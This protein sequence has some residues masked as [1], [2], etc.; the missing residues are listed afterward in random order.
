VNRVYAR[1]RNAGDI[2]ITDDIEVIFKIVV[3]QRAGQ[4]L[5]AGPEGSDLETEIGRASVLGGLGPR[6]TPTAE[7]VSE[8]VEWQPTASNESHVCIRAY[9][10]PVTGERN[11]TLNNSAQENITQWYSPAAS[12]FEPVSFEI[13]TESPWSNRTGQVLMVVPDV[14]KGWTVELEDTDFVLAPGD[15]FRQKVTITP[16]LAAFHGEI[17][18]RGFFSSYAANIE[19][20]TLVGDRFVPFGGTT[21]VV[22]PVNKDSKLV[23]TGVH[24]E[25]QFGRPNA[26]RGGITSTGP[27][28]PPLGGRAIDVRFLPVGG[29]QQWV[30]T[31]TE[32]NGQFIVT[33]PR[34]IIG[35]ETRVQAFHGGSKGIGPVAS[36]V[37]VVRAE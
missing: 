1:V 7:K 12:P 29:K 20:H 27:L 9:V 26:L 14:P 8:P 33:I 11:E 4:D 10:T 34:D 35:S 3:P 21:A 13:I 15:V 16:D 19:A 37:F 23:L 31:K 17:Q 22:H 24:S 2:P 18:D 32:V 5:D 6:G 25:D 30:R 36:N 28:R